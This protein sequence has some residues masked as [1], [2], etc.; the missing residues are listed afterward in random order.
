MIC[1]LRDGKCCH[2]GWRNATGFPDAE[3][4]RNCKGLKCHHLGPTIEREGITVTVK[5]GCTKK[6]HE[7][8]HAAHS[9]EVYGRCLPTLVPLDLNAWQERQPE[10]SIYRLCFN[11]PD[12]PGA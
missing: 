4:S 7:Q 5:C 1:D 2:C 11:C 6:E 9:C 12:K 3:V 10:S 8:P